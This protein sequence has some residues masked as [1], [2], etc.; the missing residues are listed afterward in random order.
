M[1]LELANPLVHMCVRH[2]LIQTFAQ[3]LRWCRSIKFQRYHQ[4]V[5]NL[6]YT[7]S[8][9]LV[10]SSIGLW[11]GLVLLIQTLLNIWAVRSK[12][13]FVIHSPIPLLST[14]KVEIFTS[15]EAF[16]YIM[17]LCKIL[18]TKSYVWGNN[19]WIGYLLC[20]YEKYTM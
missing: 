14:K 17:Y 7:Y 2:L 20:R 12:V 16:R 9:V 8:T 10:I 4:P 18:L 13:H 19:R 15:V 5:L 3:Y 1:V 6:S 11:T